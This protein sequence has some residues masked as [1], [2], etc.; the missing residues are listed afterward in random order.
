MGRDLTGVGEKSLTWVIGMQW[1]IRT[2]ITVKRGQDKK[3]RLRVDGCPEWAETYVTPQRI[4]KDTLAEAIFRVPIIGMVL[5]LNCIISEATEI[6]LH[7]N[8]IGRMGSA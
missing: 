6:K 4:L 2:E 1:Q 5:N 7:P 3:E 8:N